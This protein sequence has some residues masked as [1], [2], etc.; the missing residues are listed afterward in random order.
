[1][2]NPLPLLFIL[3]VLWLVG[4]TYWYNKMGCGACA[5]AASSPIL[6]STSSSSLGYA[7]ADGDV[8]AVETDNLLMYEKNKYIYEKPIE[9]DIKD[10]FKTSAKYLI[11]NE[12]KSVKITGF[13]EE[14]EE[15]IEGNN[16]GIARAKYIKRL[17][18]KLKVESSQVSL[19]SE[20]KESLEFNEENRT[21]NCLSFTFVENQDNSKEENDEFIK[22]LSMEP[23]KFY[24][25]PTSDEIIF[26]DRLKNR[27]RQFRQFTKD[28]PDQQFLV[29]GHTDSV[30][31]REANINLGLNRAGFIKKYLVDNGIS[32]EQLKVVSYGPDDP[33]ADNTTKDGRS[34]NR[35]VELKINN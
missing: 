11:N 20:M 18:E 17:F 13:Y 2:K 33:I 19:D 30:G 21:G 12:N 7:L 14:G 25:A 31:D 3:S 26:N 32:E 16:M 4:G 6:S 9:G 15:E 28:Y 24:F 34:K 29:I 27:L 23:I 8:F 35:R 5:T 1:M 10:F 22:E